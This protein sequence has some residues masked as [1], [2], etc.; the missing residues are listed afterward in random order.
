MRLARDFGTV[1][2]LF[3]PG[4]KSILDLPH[5]IYDAI[6]RALM[7]LSFRELP[8]NEQP[9]ERIWMDGEKLT[10]WFEEVRRQRARE[11]DTSDWN[12]EIEDPVQNQAALELMGG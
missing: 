12:R 10:G 4:I 3:P 11:H 8:E 9:P 2:E 6:T 7:F 1:R 5:T